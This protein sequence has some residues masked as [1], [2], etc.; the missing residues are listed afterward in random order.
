MSVHWG[1]VPVI[2]KEEGLTE[3]LERAGYKQPFIEGRYPSLD[4]LIEVISSLSEEE[5]HIEEND[6]P[7]FAVRDFTKEFTILVG[8]PESDAYICI[9]GYV[10][11][12]G[13]Y[14]FRFPGSR[15]QEITML[16]ILHSLSPICGSLIM[17]DSISATPL[18]V[19][20]GMNI[21]IALKDWRRKLKISYSAMDST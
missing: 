17:F 19:F 8:D 12:D 11:T 7:G 5:I 20:Q 4:E 14:N 13:R 16:R 18:L 15:M 10:N 21:D 9:E 6:Y 2:S 3:W 1:V